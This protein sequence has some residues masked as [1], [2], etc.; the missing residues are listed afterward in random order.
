M[1]FA[2][3]CWTERRHEKA[4]ELLSANNQ[5]GGAQFEF[6]AT[7]KTNFVWI[8]RTL[9]APQTTVKN[10]TQCLRFIGRLKKYII[11]GVTFSFNHTLIW[12]KESN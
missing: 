11:S 2:I 12:R 3:F 10:S 7:S 6:R 1:C 9:D 5:N 8:T 4:A